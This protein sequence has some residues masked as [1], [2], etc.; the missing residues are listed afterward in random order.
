MHNVYLP[1]GHTKADVELAKR[2]VV[3]LD[4]RAL[5]VCWSLSGRYLEPPGLQC[6]AVSASGRPDQPASGGSPSGKPGMSGS[7]SGASA[8]GP[9][10]SSGTSGP[11][12]GTGG[13]VSGGSWG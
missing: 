12:A 8:G 10:G 9:S 7:F 3:A 13:I 2:V 5:F 1:G 11:G 6:A 4:A